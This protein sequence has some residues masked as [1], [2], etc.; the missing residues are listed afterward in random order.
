MNE[1][2]METIRAAVTKNRG[3]W[4]NADDNAIRQIWAALPDDVKRRYLDKLAA[5]PAAIPE[6]EAGDA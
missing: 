1:L 4:E 2:P 5:A 6:Q 3:G